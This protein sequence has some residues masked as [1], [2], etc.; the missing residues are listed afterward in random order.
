MLVYIRKD[1]IAELLKPVEEEEVPEPLR[2]RCASG[3]RQLRRQSLLFFPVSS[4]HR[5][6]SAAR[7]SFAQEEDERRQEEAD[8]GDIRSRVTLHLHTE[9]DARAC[10]ER[11]TFVSKK[12]VDTEHVRVR[13]AGGAMA[14]RRTR[15]ASLCPAFPA[16]SALLI[17]PRLRPQCNENMTVEEAL[18]KA[19]KQLDKDPKRLRFYALK[20]RALPCLDP[21][22]RLRPSLAYAFPV[23]AHRPATMRRRG[24]TSSLSA[25]AST[26]P[27]IRA[28]CSLTR[29]G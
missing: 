11:I 13:N 2:K 18:L 8:R 10:S 14:A 17:P 15:L 20:V 21:C 22:G 1:K 25:L 6:R 12:L 4:A 29:P 5:P 23:L 16:A 26:S 19:A 27:T 24:Q 9:D 7:C 3:P 28:C